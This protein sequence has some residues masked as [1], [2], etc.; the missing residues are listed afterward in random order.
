ME[1][2]PPFHQNGGGSHLRRHV[3]ADTGCIV[4][5]LVFGMFA[6]LVYILMVVREGYDLF[7]LRAASIIGTAIIAMGLAGM[8]AEKRSDTKNKIVVEQT[9]EQRIA[10]LKQQLSIEQ[11]KL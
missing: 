9:I 10:E 2:D 3:L 4:A 5:V 11:R 8:I 7:G 1:G 6:F